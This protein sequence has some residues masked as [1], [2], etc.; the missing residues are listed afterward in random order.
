M[1]NYQEETSGVKGTLAKPTNLSRFL[2]KAGPGGQRPRARWRMKNM[3][4][5]QG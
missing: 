3:L 5:H 2:L 1:E 4:R